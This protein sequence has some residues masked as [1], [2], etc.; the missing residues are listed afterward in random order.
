MNVSVRANS[1]VARRPAAGV[2]PALDVA[3]KGGSV[4]GLLVVGLPARVAGYYGALILG[5]LDDKDAVD[6]LIGSASA[7]R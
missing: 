6:A 3:L 4:T 2:P 1:R 7:V 5:G